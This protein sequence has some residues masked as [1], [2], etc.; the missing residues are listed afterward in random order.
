ML[1]GTP[2]FA[3]TAVLAASAFALGIEAVTPQSQS[4]EIQI[5]LGNQLLAEGR[6]FE[7]LEAY[8]LAVE[9]S[10]RGESRVAQSGV[11]QAALRI[12]EFEK[13]RAAGAAIAEMAPADPE[14]LALYGDALWASGLFEEAEAQYDAALKIEPNLARGRHG[15]ARSLAARTQLDAALDEVQAAISLSPRD[16][17]I[18]HTL[19]TI[20]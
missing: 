7:A 9:A 13:A 8:E 5:Q 19:G 12:A 15:L 10:P 16:L 14:A 11:V 17:E 18:H 1:R 4:A 3:L 6:Y 20:F 2:A